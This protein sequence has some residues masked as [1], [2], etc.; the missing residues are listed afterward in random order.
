MQRTG[1]DSVRCLTVC[2]ALVTMHRYNAVAFDERQCC[3]NCLDLHSTT[4]H[5]T[6]TET[7]SQTA[8]DIHT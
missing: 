7:L 3:D 5:D 4:Q 2:D 1:K 8:A 6:G